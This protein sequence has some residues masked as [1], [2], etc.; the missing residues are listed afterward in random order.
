MTRTTIGYNLHDELTVASPVPLPELERFRVREAIDTPSIQVTIPA[1]GSPWAASDRARPAMPGGRRVRYHDGLG[2]FGFGMEIMYGASGETIHVQAT[3]FL[4]R[5]PHVLY[6]NVL[7][8]ILRWLFV[9]KG[10]ALVHGACVAVDDRAYLI[11]ART[12]TGKTTTILRLLDNFKDFSFLS[13]DLTLVGPDGSVLSYP[14]PLTISMHTV[15]AVNSPLLTRRERLTLPIQS[16]LHSKSGRLFG[17]FLA[18]TH[19]PMATMNGVV[20]FLVPPPKYQIDR[21]VPHVKFAERTARLAGIFVIERGEDSFE[22]LTDEK[23]TQILVENS[24]DA[25]GFPPYHDIKHLLFQ[26]ADTDLRPLEQATIANA[27]AGLPAVLLRSSTR[28][29]WRE[30]PI[31]VGISAAESSSTPQPVSVEAPESYGDLVGVLNVEPAQLS[32]D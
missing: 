16:R 24:D 4:A 11:T 32:A 8:P 1:S 13:D 19:L 5:S 15:V 10:Y 2:R 25:Y 7:E 17:L 28:D 6:T 29:W 22:L 18:R 30:I 27:V 9:E 14:K 23:A 12:D 3:P 26:T 21:L 20:Q 31:Y